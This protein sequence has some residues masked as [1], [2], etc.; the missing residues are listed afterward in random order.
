MSPSEQCCWQ[1]NIKDKARWQ[2]A[3]E[4]G[5]SL[6][7]GRSKRDNWGLSLCRV[8]RLSTRP[9]NC[10]Q[11]RRSLAS[12]TS[13][14]SFIS[15]CLIADGWVS[16]KG[17]HPPRFLHQMLIL[18]RWSWSSSRL[19]AWERCVKARRGGH[20]ILVVCI[21]PQQDGGAAAADLSSFYIKRSRGS[22]KHWALI[23]QEAVIKKILNHVWGEMPSQGEQQQAEFYTFL[24]LAF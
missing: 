2:R 3:A 13:T 12:R 11:R 4:Y 21:K 5:W 23:S 17:R 15:G 20:G 9:T 18:P 22:W 1:S 19:T 24:K 6:P 16:G 14:A 10:P 8:F 7:A